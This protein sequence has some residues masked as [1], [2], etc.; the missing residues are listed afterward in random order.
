M[1]YADVVTWLQEADAVMVVCAGAGR[2]GFAEAE[3]DR[4]LIRLSEYDSIVLR[5][6]NTFSQSHNALLSNGF[7]G[8]LYRLQVMP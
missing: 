7:V 5:P 6:S 1:Q 3:Y 8:K 2:V 4:I